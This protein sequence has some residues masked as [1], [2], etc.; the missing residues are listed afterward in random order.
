MTS[1]QGLVANLLTTD[2]RMFAP[3][4]ASGSG[5]VGSSFAQVGCSWQK[6][7][8]TACHNAK[9]WTPAFRKALPIA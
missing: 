2:K 1:W 3:A 5:L 8:T 9:T 6:V 4:P 7:P